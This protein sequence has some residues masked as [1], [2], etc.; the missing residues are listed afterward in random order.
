[1]PSIRHATTP[2]RQ[3]VEYPDTQSDD[4]PREKRAR[5]DPGPPPDALSGLPWK[6]VTASDSQASSSTDSILAHVG[7]ALQDA[8][9]LPAPTA[10]QT[11]TSTEGIQ[12]IFDQAAQ[13]VSNTMQET[14]NTEVQDV[15]LHA[16]IL[17]L[18]DWIVQDAKAAVHNTRPS[19]PSHLPVKVLEL[20]EDGQVDTTT[21]LNSLRRF[22]SLLSLNLPHLASNPPAAP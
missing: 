3:R 4:E 2:K 13:D 12:A 5:T 10:T 14:I 9:D 15:A 17:G 6:T 20:L 21:K 11:S 8:P 7:A 19:Q 22:H 1:M 18:R 16:I